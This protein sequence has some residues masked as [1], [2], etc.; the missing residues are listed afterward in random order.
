MKPCDLLEQNIPLIERVIAS[1]CRRRSF[2]DA[3][4]EDVRQEVLLKLAAD[5]CAA[6]RR[7]REESAIKT[8]VITAATRQILDSIR[9]CK[10]RWRPSEIVRR[11]GE[12]AMELERLLNRDGW[13]YEEAVEKLIAEGIAKSRAELDEIRAKLPDRPPR[14]FVSEEPLSGVGDP[15]GVENDVQERGRQELQARVR[16]ALARAVAK[17]DAEDRF[18]SKRLFLSERTVAQVARELGVDQRPLYRRRDRILG[19]FREE[20]VA[21]GLEWEEVNRLMGWQELDL[22]WDD[23]DDEDD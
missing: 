9:A 14:R 7:L 15:G 5:D 17:L 16:E 3:D 13:E 11:L 23:D 22:G 2:F 6:L 12:A 10:G 4:A 20:L 21:A 19:V 1:V 8:F 18:I